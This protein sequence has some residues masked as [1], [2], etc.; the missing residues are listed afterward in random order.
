MLMTNGNSPKILQ[1]L[2][3]KFKVSDS[4]SLGSTLN[5]TILSLKFE[6]IFPFKFWIMNSTVKS[7]LLLFVILDPKKKKKFQ[8]K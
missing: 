4:N 1:E 2:G 3:L 8:E 5:I 7:L 6:I